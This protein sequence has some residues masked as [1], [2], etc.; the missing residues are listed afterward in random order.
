LGDE[1]RVI[2]RMK[3]LKTYLAAALLI[4][5]TFRLIG[6]YVEYGSES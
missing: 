3:K 2:Y 6:D 5:Q 1:K 4:V